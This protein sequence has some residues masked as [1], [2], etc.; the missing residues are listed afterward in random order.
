MEE[1]TLMADNHAASTAVAQAA[2][3]VLATYHYPEPVQKVL[4]RRVQEAVVTYLNST[5]RESQP[6]RRVRR[7]V[8]ILLAIWLT[9]EIGEG[10]MFTIEQAEQ[11]IFFATGIKRVEVDRRLREMREVRWIFANY[12]TDPSLQPNEHRLV[13]IGDDITHKNFKWPAHQRCPADLR[14]AI[15]ERD[16]RTC[17]VCGIKAGQ[18]YPDDPGRVARLTIGR[19][20][21]GAK[22]GGYSL[23]N[24]QTECD[25]D[26]EDV[27]DRYDYGGEAA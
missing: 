25:R 15:L 27:R 9:R 16:G 24:C 22:G 5:E 17:V 26:N 2:V 3:S 4:E 8:K 11:M 12:R 18:P 23:E 10:G 21:P 6:S 20:L 7:S 19:I 13:K 14:R 1:I